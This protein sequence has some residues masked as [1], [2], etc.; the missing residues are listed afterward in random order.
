MNN[1]D[2]DISLDRSLRLDGQFERSINPFAK[3]PKTRLVSKKVG[4]LFDH[5]LEL[6]EKV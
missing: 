2:V 6:H 4:L 1:A 5:S 3:E